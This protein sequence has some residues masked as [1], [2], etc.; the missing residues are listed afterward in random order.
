MDHPF[1]GRRTLVLSMDEVKTMLA[2]DEAVEVQRRA[3]VAMAGGKT[4]AA[5]NSWLRLPGDGRRGWLKLLAGYDAESSGLGVK[6][7]ARFPNNP[8]GANLGSLLLLFDENDG[9]PLAVMD[10]V[11]VTAVRTGAGAGLATDALA[12]EEAR[13][14]GLVGTG[15]IA[16]Y[17]LLAIKKCR[18]ELRD[19]RIYSRSEE[20]RI[21]LAER[22]AAE[23]GFVTK[24]SDSVA[25]AVEGAD[26]LIT[27]TN[28]PQPV[29]MASH[30]EA[31]Q[32]LNA[33]G[34]RTEIHHE[35]IAK[36]IVVGDGREE[37]LSDGKFSIALAVGTVS[38]EDLGPSLGEVLSGAPARE[39][40]G[41][42][43]MFD[44]SGVAIQDVTCARFVYQK[45]LDEGRGMR[46]DLG[47]DGSP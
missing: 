44:S 22:A 16:W 10:G 27:A 41:E 17:S 9:F 15:V 6:V 30:L 12:P 34:I 8:P 4:T 5:P 32:H 25:S 36:C 43:T 37:T 40:P 26:V 46:V 45:A 39:A 23:L 38:E 18:P 19:L 3:F 21:K 29:L 33:M 14:V 24:V 47:L 31:G 20:R 7:L 42:I 28:S 2:M 35:A 11:Y 1:A 13:T